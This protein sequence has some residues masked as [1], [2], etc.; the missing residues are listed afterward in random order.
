MPLY[1]LTSQSFRAIPEASFTDL[2]I[3][4]RGDLQRLDS[5]FS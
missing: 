3:K 2:K 5:M 1:E 4:G